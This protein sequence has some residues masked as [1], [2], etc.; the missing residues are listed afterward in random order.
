MLCALV[1]AG[2]KGE[3]FWPLSTD[4]KPKQF[5]NLLGEESMIQLTVKRLE[6]YIS[7]ERIFIST[8]EKYKS[9]VMS[10]LPNL[11]ERNIIIEPE[12]RNTAPC[13]ALSAFYIDRIYI[14]ATLAVLPSD[15]LIIDNNKFIEDIDKGYK[16]VNENKKAIVTIG[17]TPVRPETGYGYIRYSKEK[18]RNENGVQKVESFTEKPSLEKAIEYLKEG[19]Y[20][21]NSG[22]FIWNIDTIKEL[23]NKYLNNTY[24]I[25]DEIAISEDDFDKK[26]KENYC[27]VDNISVDYGIMEKAENIHVI[28]G[29]FGW[30]D[31]GSW[32]SISRYKESDVHGNVIDGDVSSIGSK[33]NIINTNKKT[34][35][36]GVEDLIVIE[37]ES[38]L[39]IINK[40]ELSKIKELKKL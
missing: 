11:P 12:G 20:L 29:E 26:L 35:I 5:L 38:E 36:L 19:T 37:S 8:S 1:M 31:L 30:D 6:S 22:M 39:V 10:Q 4:D 3:R 17:I 34:Y 40:E 28:P 14:G 32:T 15:H 27:R 9:I 16:F 18:E 24:R 21:W 25:L 7:I 13:I 23:T 2:G 33:N